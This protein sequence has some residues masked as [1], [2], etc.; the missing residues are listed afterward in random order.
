MATVRSPNTWAAPS[1]LVSFQAEDGIRDK[2]VTGVQT[3]A[4]PISVSPEGRISPADAGLWSDAHAEAF[5]PVAAF[6]EPQGA[7]AAVQ[8][9][10]AGV[11]A[12]T[13][14]PWGGRLPLSES[15]G[16]WQALAP[17]ALP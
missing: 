16:G 5:A 15:E 2:L 17:S 10:H 3:C 7:V 1:M 9:A 14:V 8:H 11:K 13:D 12:P 4:L 6:I